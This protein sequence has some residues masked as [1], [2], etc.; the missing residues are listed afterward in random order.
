MKLVI[1]RCKRCLG[2]KKI[3]AMGSLIKDCP[4][5]DGTGLKPKEAL[6]VVS[7]DPK[8]PVKNKIK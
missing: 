2:S 5:C 8:K 1:N 4:E 3:N 7:S 6:P